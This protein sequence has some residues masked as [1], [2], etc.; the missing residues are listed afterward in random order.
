MGR[1]QFFE[2]HEQAWFPSSLRDGVTDALQFGFN[3]LKVYRTVVPLLQSALDSTRSRTGSG[4]PGGGQVAGDRSTVERCS[5]GQASVDLSIVD[6]CSGGGGPW[7]DLSRRLTQRESG[8]IK[9]SLTDKYPNV[10]AFEN[11]EAPSEAECKARVIFYSYPDAVDAMDVPDDLKGYRTLFTSFH[12]FSPEKARAILQDAVDAGEGIGIFEASRRA[13]V[14]IAL[15]FPLVLLQFLCAPF[16]CTQGIRPFRWERIFWTY[17]VP[18]IPLVLL[19]DGVVSCLRSYRP[20]ELR[21]MVGRLKAS[22][23]R[24]EYHW[25]IG[26]L[27]GTI[28]GARITYLIGYPERDSP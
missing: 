20:E 24:R 4:E 25:E 15:V 12:H 7:L 27:A 18:I 9:I 23:H 8:V 13:P 3:F 1:V 21:E 22:G 19:F 28:P 11:A 14:T 6:L 26:E 17:L 10:R 16:F 5:G 2:I